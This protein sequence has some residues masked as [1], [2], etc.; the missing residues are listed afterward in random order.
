MA[1]QVFAQI[2]GGGF[3]F[4]GAIA[5]C[6]GADCGPCRVTLDTLPR[7]VQ[8]H[9]HPSYLPNWASYAPHLSMVDKDCTAVDEVSATPGAMPNV[10]ANY[11]M[12][13]VYVP[14]HSILKGLGVTHTLAD[15]YGT[16][17]GA[18]VGSGNNSLDGLEYDVVAYEVDTSTCPPTVIPTPVA[19]A[20]PAVFAGIVAA[21][22]GTIVA[23]VAPATAGYATGDKGLMLSYKITVPPTNNPLSAINATLTIQANIETFHA[24]VR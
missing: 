7:K 6:S 1:D 19:A 17:A 15:D 16:C 11:T 9:D 20:V 2:K 23:P 12:Y 13:R 8:N 4:K 21:T 22:D 24:L 3:G 18:P 5:G 10:P 14:P